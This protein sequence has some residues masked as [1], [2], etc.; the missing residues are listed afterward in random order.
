[1]AAAAAERDDE[2]AAP[3]ALGT[4]AT[5]STSEAAFATAEEPTIPEA[6]GDESGVSTAGDHCTPD[7]GGVY[8]REAMHPSRL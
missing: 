8:R 5:F 7:A 2:A 6:S 4:A 1:M 3:K